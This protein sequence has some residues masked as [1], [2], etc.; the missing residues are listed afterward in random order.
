MSAAED[1]GRRE[2]V[3]ELLRNRQE[4]PSEEFV[5]GAERVTIELE[6]TG[7]GPFR[8]RKGAFEFV[9]DEP[10]DR[11]GEDTGPNPLAYFVG[12]AATCLLSHYML[13]AIDR[14]VEIDSLKM[15]ARGRFNRVSVGGAFQ[16]IVYDIRIESKT[17]PAEIAALA[18]Q[19][20]AMCY[21]HNTLIAGNVAMTTNVHV[22]GQL[23]TTLEK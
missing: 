9:V 23:V 1:S 21:A 5:H 10:P 4:S 3:Q 6:G 7:N 22:N 17:P 13:C 20:E 8:V 15:A 2:A 14:G 18:E 12:G 11:G 16:A 19:A